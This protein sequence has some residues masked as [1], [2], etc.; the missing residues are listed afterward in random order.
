MNLFYFTAAQIEIKDNYFDTQDSSPPET[1]TFSLLPGTFSNK[2][3]E[4]EIYAVYVT[5]SNAGD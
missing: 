1:I 2:N 5:E 4:I 3:G